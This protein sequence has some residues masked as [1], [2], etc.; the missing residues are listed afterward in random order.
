MAASE[1]VVEVVGGMVGAAGRWVG[2][3]VE[4]D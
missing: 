2:S 3:E 1:G 4:L